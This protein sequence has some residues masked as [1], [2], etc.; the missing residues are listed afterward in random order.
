MQGGQEPPEWAFL[1]AV[2]IILLNLEAIGR[3]S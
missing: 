1:V 3:S 2:E